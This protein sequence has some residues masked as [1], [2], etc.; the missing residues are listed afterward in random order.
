MSRPDQGL[1]WRERTL[2][3]SKRALYWPERAQRPLRG[4]SLAYEDQVLALEYSSDL[5]SVSALQGPV[6][7]DIFLNR[8][9]DEDE[10]WAQEVSACN[11]IFHYTLL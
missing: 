9:I 7:G 11:L 1:C 2:F 8:L 4:L 5:L 3:L 10:T 6:F